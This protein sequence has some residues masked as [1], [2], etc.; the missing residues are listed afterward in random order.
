MVFIG[1]SF[2]SPREELA[3]LLDHA[4]CLEGGSIPP[5]RGQRRLGSKVGVGERDSEQGPWA[6]AL[7]RLETD[8]EG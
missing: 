8:E 6:R 3:T 1:N 2:P 5:P 4:A 7:T